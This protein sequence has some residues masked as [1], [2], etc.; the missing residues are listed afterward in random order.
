VLLVGHLLLHQERSDRALFLGF[1][2]L[3]YAHA[4]ESSTSVFS[5]SLSLKAPLTT[6][7]QISNSTHSS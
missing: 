2:Q 3:H 4:V 7:T 6:S 5:S 1:F